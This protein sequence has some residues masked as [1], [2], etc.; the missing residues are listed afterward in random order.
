VSE[1]FPEIRNMEPARAADYLLYLRRIR[2][3]EIQLY[4]RNQDQVSC[5][6]TDRDAE[7][8]SNV[9]P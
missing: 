6:I 5:R 8:E 9:V 7:G 2:R 4:M 3:I 1:E